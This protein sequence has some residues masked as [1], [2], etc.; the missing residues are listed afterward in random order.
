MADT[1]TKPAEGGDG[2]NATAL[3]K[4]DNAEP[5]AN[6]PTAENPEVE[7]SESA[8]KPDRRRFFSTGIFSLGL[9]KFDQHFGS[10]NFY[11]KKLHIVFRLIGN[12]DEKSHNRKLQK[13]VFTSNRKLKIYQKYAQKSS[14]SF[15]PGTW[16]AFSV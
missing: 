10:K 6:P 3:E 5:E 8:D 13:Y 14:A 15:K 7:P 2:E 9:K 16:S 1:E 12:N 11:I 4:P